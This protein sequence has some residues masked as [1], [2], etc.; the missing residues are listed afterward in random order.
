M[1]KDPYDVLGVKRDASDA[2]IQKAFRRLAKKSHPDLYP[3]D[4]KAEERFKD[5]NAAN[6]ILGDPTKRARFDR[7]E[8]DAGG[9][10][11]RQN[12][13]AGGRARAGGFGGGGAEGFAFD[14]LGDLFGGIFRGQRG[15]GGFG[16]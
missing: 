3:G 13:F 10:E 8:I 6:D 5:L 1:A 16:G 15:P 2:E 4:K 7:G 11:V 9:A 12:P 14:D